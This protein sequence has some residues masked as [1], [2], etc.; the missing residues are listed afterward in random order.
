LGATVAF[1]AI[2]PIVESQDNVE[3]AEVLL[4]HIQEPHGHRAWPQHQSIKL[5][6]NE[7]IEI[8]QLM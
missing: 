5:D 4:L 7:Q 2:T 8:T 3:E 6:G 1:P